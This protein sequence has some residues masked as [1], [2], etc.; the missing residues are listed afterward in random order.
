MVGIANR[1]RGILV[2]L[3]I[4]RSRRFGSGLQLSLRFI[5][6]GAV[7]QGVFP[8]SAR[9][10]IRWR[11]PQPAAR[12][13]TARPAADVLRSIVAAEGARHIV[14][15]FSQPMDEDVRQ[16]LRQAGIELLAPLGDNAFFALARPNPQGADLSQIV[17]LQ[18]AQRIERNMKEHPMIAAGDWPAYAL[19][20]PKNGTTRAPDDIVAVYALFHAD[21]SMKQAVDVAKAHHADVKEELFTINALVLELPQ[22][23]VDLLADRDEVQ[24]IEPPLPPMSATNDSNRALT[25]ANIVQSVPYNLTGTG[26]G[27]MVYDAGTGRATHQ[28]FGGRLTVRDASGLV[29]H[30]THV[31]GTIG[32]SGV[33]S[34]GLRKGMAPGVTLEAYGLQTNGSGTFLYDNPGDL[35]SDYNQAINTFGVDLASNSIGTNVESNGFPCSLQGDYG[36][37]DQLIDSIVRGSLGPPFRIMW[38]AGNERQGTRCNVEGFGSYYSVAPPAG[39]KNQSASARSIP[40]TT[41]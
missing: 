25:Q 29:D 40:T 10:E 32:G 19:A 27:V 15:Q 21:V 13:A 38:A 17:S 16:S 24:W 18:S 14:L 30:S 9:S 39:A 20:P 8:S 2:F 22:N 35:Q 4:N 1:C 41:A 6:A 34:G 12:A 33:A 37:T 11:T 23:Q 28:D 31:A 36:I 5:A 3:N 26:V 7:V